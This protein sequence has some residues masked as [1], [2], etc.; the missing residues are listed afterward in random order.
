MRD[1]C[2]ATMC[3]ERS[4]PQ[5]LNQ[6]SFSQTDWI[7]QFCLEDVSFMMFIQQ[8]V[9]V[10]MS[11]ISTTG[12]R[13]HKSSDPSTWK[14][15]EQTTFGRYKTFARRLSDDR[16]SERAWLDISKK[17]EK[18]KTNNYIRI[19]HGLFIL[20]LYLYMQRNIW[21]I[22]SILFILYISIHIILDLI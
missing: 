12:L 11:S 1:S 5:P 20:I 14:G 6:H 9:A 7:T 21:Y 15:F 13:S 8:I 10:N 22:N 4:A 17:N 18:K 16:I 19:K 3:S 2:A